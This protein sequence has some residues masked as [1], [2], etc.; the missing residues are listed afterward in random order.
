MS[1]DRPALDF[2]IEPE[3]PVDAEAV[4]R[5]HARIFGPGRFARTAYRLREAAG[6][7][8]SASFVA[9]VN[10]LMVGAVA[11]TPVHVGREQAWLLGPLVVEPAFK[12]RGIGRALIARA[13]RLAEER[14]ARFVLLVGDLAYYGAS[15]FASVP[16]GKLIL[17]GPVD[18][19]RVLVRSLG[20]ATAAELSGVVRPFWSEIRPA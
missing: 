19:A 11:M 15:G 8:P 18:P 5:L 16:P 2:T 13:V 12:G 7:D 10:T 6:H 3:R 20:G 1:D 9:R 17:P 14:S 4:E